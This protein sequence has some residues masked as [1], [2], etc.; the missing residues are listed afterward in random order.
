MQNSQSQDDGL[1]YMSLNQDQSSI[2]VGTE[3]GFKV[4][5]TIP[6]KLRYQRGKINN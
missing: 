6:L 1:L 5:D 3:N 4:Y 2:V